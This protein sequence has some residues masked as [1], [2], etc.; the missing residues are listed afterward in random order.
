MPVVDGHSF[1][2]LTKRVN[3]AGRHVT[4]YLTQLLRRRGYALTRGADADAIRQLKEAA[5]FV[6]LDYPLES[7]AGLN[8]STLL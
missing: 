6:A 8:P 1:P 7:K 2:H 5:C 4:S 3:I